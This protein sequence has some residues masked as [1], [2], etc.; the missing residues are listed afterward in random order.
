M[1]EEVIQSILKLTRTRR[2]HAIFIFYEQA[3]TRVW[4]KYILLDIHKDSRSHIII[5]WH[6]TVYKRYNGHYYLGKFKF[7]SY[8]TSGYKGENT[9]HKKGLT[10]CFFYLS[11]ADKFDLLGIWSLA[12]KRSIRCEEKKRKIFRLILKIFLFSD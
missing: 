11:I 6:A 8:H 3:T 4:K 2:Q 7:T 5:W 12:W 1:E 9:L 10:V